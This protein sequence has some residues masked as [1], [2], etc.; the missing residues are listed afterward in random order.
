MTT[1]NT[2]VGIDPRMLR[3]EQPATH[4]HQLF[5]VDEIP[6]VDAAFYVYAPTRSAVEEIVCER[7]ALMDLPLIW[8][9]IEAL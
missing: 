6:L 3:S 5:K 2:L 8:R 7:A 1:R 4:D 9:E